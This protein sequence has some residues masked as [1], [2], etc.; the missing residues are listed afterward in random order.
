MDVFKTGPDLQCSAK[1]ARMIYRR[2]DMGIAIKLKDYLDSRHVHYDLLKH[3]YSDS[4][5]QAAEASHVSGEKIA[6]AVLLHDDD[7]YVL[8]IVPATH[9]LHLGRL[10]RRFNRQLVLAD[11]T[12]IPKLFDDCSYGAIPA[13]GAAYNADVIVDDALMDRPEEIYFEAGD[14]RCLVHMQADEFHALLANAP[15]GSFSYHL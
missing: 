6:K 9:K 2:F 15:H 10:R 5:M 14:H 11:E 4:T 8:A 13:L 1:P 7:D 3:D 12:D